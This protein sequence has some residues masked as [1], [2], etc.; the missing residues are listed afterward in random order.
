MATESL[1]RYSQVNRIRI[2]ISPVV[3]RL[4][5]SRHYRER[6]P[7]NNPLSLR[8]RVRVRA[9]PVSGHT[10]DSRFRWNHGRLRKGLRED[11]IVSS[12]E[13]GVFVIDSDGTK[14]RTLWQARRDDK[15]CVASSP[16]ISPGGSR[17]IY[18]AYRN[19]AFLPWNEN[20]RSEIIVSDPDGSNEKTLIESGGWFGSVTI[21]QTAE[22]PSL[23][24]GRSPNRLDWS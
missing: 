6:R 20:Y 11:Y 12:H 13:G 17:I 18:A 23:G 21:R 22:S 8:E 15:D 19:R 16:D 2:P 7:L 5:S 9:S 14:L 24:A 4:R 3:P 10:L 1:R